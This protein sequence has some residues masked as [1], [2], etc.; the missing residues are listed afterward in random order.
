MRA[1][2]GYDSHTFGADRPLRL[3]GVEIAHPTGLMGHSDGDAVAHALT[4]ALLGAA[5]LG[6]IG[7]HFP[8]SD[9]RW[10][11]AD[12][13]TMLATTAALVRDAGWEPVN[14][15]ATVVTE[16]PKLA[17]HVPAMRARLAEALG[18]PVDAVSVKGKSN[19]GMDAV[20]RGEGLQVFA[21]ATVERARPTGA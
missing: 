7:R 5:A 16:A 14:V 13:L 12:S 8:D 3:A 2:F 6:D 18:L 4:D 20:G 1:G 11:G 21:I 15:D 10:K 9:P 17:P 19:E